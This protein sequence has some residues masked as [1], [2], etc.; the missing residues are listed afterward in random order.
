MIP[1]LAIADQGDM[2]VLREMPLADQKKLLERIL[3]CPPNREVQIWAKHILQAVC[4]LM[5]ASRA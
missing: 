5:E 1:V 2:A 4:E 3:L